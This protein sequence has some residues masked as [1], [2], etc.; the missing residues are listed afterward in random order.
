MTLSFSCPANS[1]VVFA[2][3]MDPSATTVKKGPLSETDHAFVKQ[4][5]EELQRGLKPTWLLGELDIAALYFARNRLNSQNP[6]SQPSAS[7]SNVDLQPSNSPAD[8]DLAGSPRFSS[9]SV[10][11]PSCNIQPD[12]D[13]SI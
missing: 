11:D 5:Y 7:T 6:S 13:A 3:Q 8:G 12:E 1:T 10:S 2:G 9:K 4:W